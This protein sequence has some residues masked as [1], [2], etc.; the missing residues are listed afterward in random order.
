VFTVRIRL[1]T[2]LVV[3]L[4]TTFLISSLSVLTSV[5]DV[6]AATGLQLKWAANLGLGTYV[7]PLAAYLIPGTKEMQIVVT[8][9]SPVDHDFRNGSVAVLNGSDG[10]I[11]WKVDP[12]NMQDH[13]PF[14]I[15]DLNNDG[16]ME[17]VVANLENTLV[18]YGN[19][20]STYWKNTAAPSYFNYP[21]VF[22]VNGDG[23]LEVFVCSGS[24][25]YVGVD[26]ITELSHDGQI[27]AQTESWHPCWGGLAIGDP[28]FNGTFILVQGDR[29]TYYNPENDTYKYGGWGV[30][31]LD[32]NTLTTI[33]NDSSVIT[34]SNIPMLVDVNGDSVLEVVATMQDT[35]LAVYNALNGT[36]LSNDGIYRKDGNVSLNSHSQP[37]IYFDSK[38]EPQL[39]TCHDSNPKIWNL[40]AWNLTATL[41]VTCFE[42]PKMGR[43]T[44][45]Q[46]MGI[47]VVDKS[48]TVHV[49][50]Q[51]FQEVDNITLG[52]SDPS[53]F[54]LVQDVDGD[55][56]NELL[57]TSRSGTVYCYGTPALALNPSPRSNVAFCSEYRLG[58]AEY[59]EPPGPKAPQIRAPSPV[60]GA[61][62]LPT[63]LSTL[64]VDLFDYQ[65][66]PMNYSVTTT[67]NIGEAS[68]TNLPNGRYNVSIA[69]LSYST[70][71]SWT[72][73]VT[74]GK[75]SNATTFSF[76]TVQ[77]P[78]DVN[79]GSLISSESPP[80]EA[81]G[82][83]ISLSTLSFD[84]TNFQVK[85]MNYTVS[86]TPN[87][88][89]GSGTNVIDDRYS[90]HVSGLS[91][92]TTYSWT[93]NVTDGELCNATAF[94]FTTQAP[95]LTIVQ[96]IQAIKY[97]VMTL[98]SDRTLSGRQGKTLTNQL[99]NAIDNFSDGKYGEAINHIE[100]F[101]NQVNRLVR[102][103][104]LTQNQA[105]KLIKP[106]EDAI[107]RICAL[108]LPGDLNGDKTVNVYDS[109]LLAD[110]FYVSAADPAWESKFDLQEDGIIDI[111]DALLLSM[112]FGKSWR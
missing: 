33:W 70:T 30:R 107:D 101:I 93:V 52:S 21:V 25:P 97:E 8:G 83:A 3:A 106:A 79:V 53:A 64:S 95:Q 41:N 102:E 59:V 35:G 105:D 87:I 56:Y 40:K 24:A 99:D 1:R 85:P 39:I 96:Q 36:V 14:E 91:Y 108:V 2:S 74:D 48:S 63:S 23:Y 44:A 89:S 31:V 19:N 65:R 26:Y 11:M 61:I 111:F 49:Y 16:N 28:Y 57:M 98:V 112:N 5:N 104:D 45:D 62:D 94:T 51:N 15:A 75:N 90:I 54:T 13:S 38:G 109:L 18:L 6:R 88:G 42:P 67:P 86:T 9:V 103:H 81:T 20:G 71:Y 110:K 77:P 46:Q 73:N 80:D 22:D 4:V 76:T 27:L 7:G 92:S 100:E 55:G 47:I 12:G 69:N 37:T 82:V 72:V 58:V 32:P 66:D 60:N 78:P 50:N 43:V 34:S 68:G 84:L 10:S 17:I 29:S